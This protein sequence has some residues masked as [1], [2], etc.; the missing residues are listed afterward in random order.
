MHNPFDDLER[1]ATPPAALRQ[2][3]LGDLRK[4]GL[5]QTKR[6]NLFGVVARMAAALALVALGA[7]ASRMLDGGA[8]T[9]SDD[10]AA[11]PTASSTDTT[12]FA[13]L[14]YEPSGFDTTRTH[15]ELAA[16]YG[17][18]AR[19]L[20]SRFV[21]GEALGEE[22]VVGGETGASAASTPTGFFIIRSASWEAAMSIAGTCPH[23]RH[24]GVVA[25]RRIL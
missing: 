15:A 22:R 21:A 4:R 10:I 24:G 17:A 14:L 5:V 11:V 19:T 18:W 25:V 2:R 13:L 1:E 7:I 3:V 9:G 20:D 8:G 23:L 16:E 6:A 12:Q